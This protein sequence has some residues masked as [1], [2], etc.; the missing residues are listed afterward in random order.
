MDVLAGRTDLAPLGRR[1][2]ALVTRDYH[3]SRLV[4]AIEGALGRAAQRR[5]PPLGGT[6]QAYHLAVLAEKLTQTAV[7]ELLPG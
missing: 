1:T 2:Q 4:P 7:Q 5:R 3:L 6:A